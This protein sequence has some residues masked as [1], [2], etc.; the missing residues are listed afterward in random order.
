[1]ECDV[2]SEIVTACFRMRSE[3][4]IDLLKYCELTDINVYYESF[5]AKTAIIA[6]K[7]KEEDI[8]F[9]KL[10]FKTRRW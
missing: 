7:A 5:G 4:A 1:M 9:L 2:S 3:D 8:T 10:L 6:L